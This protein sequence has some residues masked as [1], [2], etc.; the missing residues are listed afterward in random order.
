MVHTNLLLVCQGQQL[1]AEDC[2]LLVHGKGQVL[3][4][5]GMFQENPRTADARH[6]GNVCGAGVCRESTPEPGRKA[7]LPTVS[8]QAPIMPAS[9][10]NS[11]S[12]F[13]QER[14][15]GV[16][17]EL[18]GNTLATGKGLREEC[19]ADSQ[20]PFTMGSGGPGVKEADTQDLEGLQWLL[21][22]GSPP[23]PAP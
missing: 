19:C 9:K 23:L 7:L 2:R 3:G 11:L 12:V 14:Q 4:K 22:G 8:D 16:N 17:L 13:S 21:L 10:G 15:R 5:M 6:W 20:V 1:P 18:I